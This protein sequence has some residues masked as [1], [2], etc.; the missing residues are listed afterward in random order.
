MTF[1]HH[2]DGFPAAIVPTPFDF[3]DP[4]R[5]TVW[6]AGHTYRVKTE[7]LRPLSS[8]IEPNEET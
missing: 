5:V 2:L 6:V 3:E 4:D 7:V 8:T 1:N